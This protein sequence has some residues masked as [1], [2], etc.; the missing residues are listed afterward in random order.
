MPMFPCRLCGGSTAEAFRGTVLSKYEIGYF[1]C[2]HCGSLETEPPYWLDEAY[3]THNLAEADTGAARRNL[4]Y[5]AAVYAIARFLGLGVRTS[6]L[7]YGGG[8]GLLCRLLRD[9]GFAADVADRYA[10]NEFAQ[11]FVDNGSRYEIVTAIEVAEHFANPRDEMQNIFGRSRSVCVLGTKMYEGQGADWWYLTPTSGQHV[12]F[13]S[14]GAM[15]ALAASY[16]YDYLRVGTDFH[17]FLKRPFRWRE[18]SLIEFG[19]ASRRLKWVR[20]YL[21]LRALA[22][23]N[24]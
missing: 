9:L 19:L 18:K 11:G 4:D 16:R 22:A 14:G 8:S 21:A 5:Q 23:I 10:L 20:A 15:A 12:F 7:D 6:V 2:E 3:S 13:Y 24:G 1:R 17:L